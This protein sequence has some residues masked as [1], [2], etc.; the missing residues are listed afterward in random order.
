MKFFSLKISMLLFCFLFLVPVVATATPDLEIV[1]YTLLSKKRVTR[2]VYEYEY[3]AVIANNGSDAEN[4]TASL[5][6]S[7]TNT[8]L[9]D[10]DLSFGNVPEAELVTSTNTFKIRQ[11]RL[12]PFDPSAMEWNIQYDESPQTSISVEAGLSNVAISIGD[13]QN[14]AYIVTFSSNSSDSYNINF[15]Q[16]ITPNNGG[17][18]LTT[19]Y[20]PGWATNTSKTWTVNETIQGLS[21]GTYE[22]TTVVSIV[23][24][25]QTNQVTTIVNVLGGD[26]DPIINTLGS[27]PDAINISTPTNVLF[28]CMISNS[29]LI[30][31]EFIIEEIN[32]NGDVINIIGS[33]NDQGLAGDL[34]SNDSVYSGIFEIQY[35]T[36]GNKFFQAKAIFSQI[37]ATVFSDIHKLSVTS[38]PTEIKAPDMNMVVIDENTGEKILSN[39]ITV[40]F[41]ENVESSVIQNIINAE[42]G[43]IVGSISGVDCYQIELPSEMSSAEIN[44][45]LVDLQVYDEILSAEPVIIGDIQ[46]V[47]PNDSNFSSQWGVTKIRAD[48]AWVIARG[49]VTIA[50]LD[51]GADYNH[52]DIDSKIIKGRNYHAGWWEPWNWYDPI[53]GHSHGT[54]VSGICAAETNNSTGVAG[55]SWGSKVL[56]V[57]VC[58]DSGGCPENI[59]AKGIKYA[60][61]KGAKII[62]MSLRFNSSSTALKKACDY[63][64][65][66]GVLIVAAAGNDND[67]NKNYPAAYSNV[68]AV[69]N[70]TSS[71]T[72]YTGTYGSCYGNWVNIAAPGTNIYSTI[73]N[74]NYGNKTG[75]SMASPMVAGAAAVVWAKHPSWT[76]TKVRQR[77]EQTAKPLTGL[78]LGAGRIDL[79]EAVF[80]GSFE[81]GDLSEWA[82]T[83]TA[84]SISSLGSIVPVDRNGHKERFGYVST[85]PAADYVSSKLT[86]AFRIQSGVNSIPVSFDYNF[87]TEEYPEWVGSIYDDGVNITLKTPS[88][89]IVTLATESVNGSSFSPIT[90]IDFPGGDE[91]VGMT[92][93]KSKTVTVPVTEGEG[94]YQIF[95]ED[96]GDDIY[97]SVIL[98]DNIRFK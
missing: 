69:G 13:S 42:G 17:V 51:T 97:D 18:S 24:T 21:V 79:F 87:V 85:G 37:P 65:S 33:L 80:N 83:G 56:A 8:T 10:G 55:V 63:A 39:Q 48:E 22:I 20:P 5:T 52:P 53:D 92:G 66:K 74:N 36:E 64:A 35:E 75:T 4:V 44:A 29:D 86:Q 54:H 6:V 67:S 95:V 12:Y 9:V 76:A 34:L 27:T 88:G 2:T 41:Q 14:I 62:N 19:D 1:N 43:T 60:A 57:K 7:S 82:R 61:D 45:V 28:T 84:S 31:T 32:E 25:G 93:W 23:E 70:T 71:D 30:P 98:I 77:L 38:L 11:N 72:R 94:E 78:Q 40:C 58:D 3:Q 16:Q 73:L 89:S 47:T 91:T 50:V 96:A 26:E 15:E 59:V 46:A 81:V 68:F 49:N 90:G